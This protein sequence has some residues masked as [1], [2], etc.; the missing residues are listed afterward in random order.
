MILNKDA[1]FIDNFSCGK[2]RNELLKE[3]II[4][5]GVPIGG[6]YCYSTIYIIILNYFQLNFTLTFGMPFW[7]VIGFLILWYFTCKLAFNYV[8]SMN[9]NRAFEHQKL[10]LKVSGEQNG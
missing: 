5:L 10:H 2:C 8:D 9:W 4:M 1:G 7:L 3:L 6:I